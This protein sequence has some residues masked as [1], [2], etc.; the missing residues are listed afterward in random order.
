MR[1]G[2]RSRSDR[3]AALNLRN[4]AAPWR[5]PAKAPATMPS[6]PA[7]PIMSHAATRRFYALR[8]EAREKGARGQQLM[9]LLRNMPTAQ[10]VAGE[11]ASLAD[12]MELE[13]QHWQKQ[14]WQQAKAEEQLWQQKVAAVKQK[15][16]KGKGK[17]LQKLQE[18]QN[19]EESKAENARNQWQ[20]LQAWGT[21]VLR[22]MDRFLV[23]SPDGEL[24]SQAKQLFPDVKYQ[25]RLYAWRWW[26]SGAPWEMSWDAVNGKGSAEIGNPGAA[27]KGGA[28]DSWQDSKATAIGAAKKAAA[29]AP[30][31]A[32]AKLWTRATALE[33]SAA[34]RPW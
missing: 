22:L 7:V 32:A 1:V 5:N 2:G 28:A 15:G 13:G 16:A 9:Q 20:E 30:S 3:L 18:E 11:G 34:G 10:M 33:A 4:V 6:D 25:K 29:C 21:E 12:A 14:R 17:G 31:L 24:A 27:G 8:D 26:M 19:A 23:H